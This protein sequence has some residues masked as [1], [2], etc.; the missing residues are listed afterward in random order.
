MKARLPDDEGERLQ[1]L[2]DYAILDTPFEESFDDLTKLAA[3][4][5]AAPIALLSLVDADRQW[6]KAKIGLTATETS[7]DLAF[8]AHAILQDDL[9]VVADARADPRFAD[10]GLVTGEPHIRFYA[11]SPLRTPSGYKLGTL[12]VL[13]YVTRALT[14]Q[15]AS[16]LRILSRQ[17]SSQLELRKVRRRIET[18]ETQSHAAAEAL[19]ESEELNTRIV[20]SSGDCF[21][22]L[23]L[24][25]RL[26]SM[27]AGGMRVLEIC[28]LAPLRNLSWIDF[29]QGDDREAARRAVDT[30][31]NG[32]VGRFVGF[33]ATTQ[34]GKPMWWDVVV[35]AIFGRD[36]KPEK[37]LALSRDVTETKRAE[38]LLR[39]VQKGTATVTGSD[40]LYSLVRHLAAALRL[41]YAFVA[42]CRDKV[43]ARSVAFWN[44]DGFGENF[45]YDLVG[46]PCLN[47][48]QGRACFYPDNLQDL[49]PEDVGLADW[50]AKSYLGVPLLDSQRQIIGHLVVID[51]RPMPQDALRVSVLETFAARAGLELERQVADERLRAA[52]AEVE[53]LKNKLEA[54]NVYLQE[55]IQT[56]HNFREIVGSSPPLLDALRKV[57]KVSGTDST[58][59]ILGETG[60]GKELFARAIHSRS[61][62]RE[63]PLV[64]VNCGAIAAGLV[65][66]ELFGHVKGA[67]TGALQNR[68]GRFELADRGTIFL[69]E[70]SELPAETQVKLLRVLQEQEFEPVGSSRTVK[71]NVRVLAASN[72]DLGEAVRAGRFRADLLYR[73]NVFP[74]LVPP[75]RQRPTD[76]PLLAGFFLSALS[77]K[78][79]KPL[80]GF[81]RSST[82]R[83][84]SYAWPGNVRELANIV[85][86]AAILGPGPV[87]EVGQELL[88]QGSS[89]AAQ[90]EESSQS[91]RDVERAHIVETL[92]STGG[93]VEGPAGAA[94]LLGINPN[95]LRSRMKKL[96][97]ER[98]DHEISRP[99]RNVVG[100]P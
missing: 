33:F 50:G 9:T 85:E 41:R 68:I 60:V 49:F 80:E 10:N 24:E 7:R 32:Q 48:L 22:V 87:L 53:A 73:L 15:Q 28:D 51:D 13:D 34:T 47:V 8:C 92:R 57:E 70:V 75:L 59:L 83:M 63:R 55:E 14:E 4:V 89:D 56:Q 90:A 74:I 1:E 99:P 78:L 26:L 2:S 69:D 3:E 46:T 86:R 76:I 42:E 93:V 77:K 72:R 54:E 19:R 16:A 65:E 45:E 38:D 17:A 88:G 12:C 79:G 66:S 52:L 30:A 96:G 23:D 31:R 6:F 25:G 27:N 21:K 94:R 71:V 81:N 67:F 64:K 82:D 18:A 5:C 37:L 11:G 29:W 61:A 91:L 43:H 84:M 98:Q 20:E 97:I 100:R 39:A 40:F 95:T 36:G 35:N 44:G 58:V 62:R